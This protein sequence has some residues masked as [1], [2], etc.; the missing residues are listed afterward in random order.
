MTKEAEHVL[1]ASLT[2]KSTELIQFLPYLLQDLWEL[3]SSPDD[4]VL[5]IKKHMSL[6]QPAKILDLACGKGAV[7]VRVAEKLGAH[8][9][10]YDIM[11]DFI[12]FAS[13]KAEEFGVGQLCTFAMGDANEIVVSPDLKEIYDCVIFGAA[14]NVLGNPAQTLK[15]LSGLT[16]P[17]GYIIMD[18]SFLPDDTD[19]ADV[20][21]GY[22]MLTKSEW[23][24]LFEKSGLRLIEELSSG[25]DYD[26]ERDMKAIETR[27]AELSEIHPEKKSLFEGYVASQQGE[28]DDLE[29][30]LISVSWILQKDF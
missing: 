15:K 1:A 20:K 6:T 18:E 25:K 16:K 14:G 8:V 22:E 13:K 2:A 11:P 12:R 9:H 5:L 19:S 7:S 27:A 29:N 10:G 26:F 24:N 3:G 23:L 21:Y 30:R 17:G 28:V 4:I